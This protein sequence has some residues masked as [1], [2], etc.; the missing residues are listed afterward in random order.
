MLRI[1]VEK[2]I[3]DKLGKPLKENYI[4]K[5]PSRFIFIELNSVCF[6]IPK[7]ESIAYAKLICR[8]LFF[9]YN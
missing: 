9:N 5:E 8:Y 3:L 2:V 4:T 7:I 6:V 1:N